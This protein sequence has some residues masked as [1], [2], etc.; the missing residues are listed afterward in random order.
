MSKITMSQSE[1]EEFL[2]ALHVGVIAAER[3]GDRAPLAVPVWYTYSPG[4]EVMVW[5]ERGTVKERLIRASGRFSLC[6]QQEA[7]PY[8][9]VSVEGPATFQDDV[10][11][12][13]VR[14]LVHRYLPDAEAEAFIGESFNDKAVLIRMLPERWFTVDYGKLES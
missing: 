13:D 1:R 7:P 2:A 14:P 4:G 11:A 6:A 8:R 3:D 10:T 5:T 9:H 12:D